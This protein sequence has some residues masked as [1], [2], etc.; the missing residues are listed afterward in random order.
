MDELSTPSEYARGWLPFTMTPPRKLAT[1]N[2][3]NRLTAGQLCQEK[4]RGVTL[5]SCPRCNGSGKCQVCN[6]R[7]KVG[8]LVSS[9]CRS[10]DPR[11]T[12][13]CDRC[14]GK[15]SV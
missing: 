2:D 14:K 9:D 7:G 11:G 6:G 4:S 10:C 12:G 13:K 3:N 15:G 8:S 5:A 1:G